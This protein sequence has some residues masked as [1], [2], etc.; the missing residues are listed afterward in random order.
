MKKQPSPRPKADGK[1]PIGEQRYA[2]L[3]AAFQHAQCAIEEQRY[4]EAI[5][6]LESIILDR[7]SSLV[8]GSLDYDIDL[9]WTIGRIRE[10]ATKNTVQ[11]KGARGRGTK[12]PLPADIVSFIDKDVRDWFDLRNHAIHGMAK[13]RHAGDDTFAQRYAK[14]DAV[15]LDGVRVLLQ[16]DQLD[17]RQ[18]ERNKAGRSATWP[19]ALRLTPRIEL[20]IRPHSK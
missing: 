11:A 19:D 9:K 7:L 8:G 18:K 13:L 15:A 3:R 4:L 10:L 1:S 16:L 2:L 12:T 14:L 20:L 5:P 6:V 17:V